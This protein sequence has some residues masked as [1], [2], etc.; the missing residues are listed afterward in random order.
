M[1]ATAVWRP[2]MCETA[3]GTWKSLEGAESTW[4]TFVRQLISHASD[5]VLIRAQTAVGLNRVSFDSAAV[6]FLTYGRSREGKASGGAL[7]AHVEGD[8]RRRLT[9]RWLHRAGDCLSASRGSQ[10]SVAHAARCS[11]GKSL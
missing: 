2:E 6:S 9:G 8:G 1:P 7:G 5:C 10:G 11:R 3:E 4:A